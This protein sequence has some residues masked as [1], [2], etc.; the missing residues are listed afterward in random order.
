MAARDGRAVARVRASNDRRRRPRRPNRS[1]WRTGCRGADRACR[2]RAADSGGS[3]AARRSARTTSTRL[4]VRG[5]RCRSSRRSGCRSGRRDSG[6]STRCLR[7]RRPSRSTRTEK[8]TLA[9][10]VQLVHAGHAG[11]GHDHIE[12]RSA[13]RVCIAHAAIVASR[14]TARRCG[15]GQRSRPLRHRLASNPVLSEGDRVN[16]PARQDAEGGGQLRQE[17]AVRARL[18]PEHADFAARHRTDEREQCHAG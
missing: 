17:L 4:R 5:P 15:A 12:I 9:E 8:P 16:Q 1:A 7:R 11:P 14:P 2:R 10:Q 6:S 18:A 13:H 3:P